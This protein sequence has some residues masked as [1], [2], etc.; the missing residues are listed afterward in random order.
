MV[1]VRARATLVLAIFFLGAG[2]FAAHT[3]S[4]H[5]GGYTGL[6][7]AACAVCLALADLCESSF[8]RT[9]FPI[10]PLAAH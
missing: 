10:W 4:S 2:R 9:V 3:T 8:G 5:W 6:A 1:L 7:A